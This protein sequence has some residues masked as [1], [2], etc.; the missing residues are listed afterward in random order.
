MLEKLGCTEREDGNYAYSS[1]LDL[2]EGFP[3]T[4]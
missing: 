3:C 4:C 1:F 2:E